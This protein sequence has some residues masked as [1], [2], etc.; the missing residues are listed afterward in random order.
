MAP[1]SDAATDA[2][3]I[4][5]ATWSGV[6]PVDPVRVARAL[7]IDVLDAPLSPDVS[8]ALVK[9]AGQDPSI[10]LNSIDSLNR[11]RFSCTHEIGHFVRR[12]DGL[13]EYE[14]V[15]YRNTF[16]STG[17]DPEEVYANNFAACLLMPEDHVKRLHREGL[18]DVQMALRFDVSREAM[19]YR[20]KNLGLAK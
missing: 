19:E 11:Q 1:R 5:A 3:R 7:G 20:L 2:A 16:S 14:Y 18:S 17:Q 4:L 12:R 6:L 10:L 15:D 9:E 13:D 8:A